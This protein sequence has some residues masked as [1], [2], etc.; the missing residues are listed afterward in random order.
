MSSDPLV[1][2]EVLI[3]FH[4]IGSAVKVTAMDVASLTE[5]S[6]QGSASSG[7]MALK[8]AALQRLAYVLRKKGI[9]V[10]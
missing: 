8:S 6:I 4:R 3:E 7:E 5:I 10:S 2:R 1:G 9:L